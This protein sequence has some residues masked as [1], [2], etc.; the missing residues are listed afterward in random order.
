MKADLA[1]Q[2]HELMEHGMRPVTM[3]DIESR[4]PVR[5]TVLQRATSRT[6]LA[7]SRLILA[8]G[9]S[10]ASRLDRGISDRG[11]PP[12]PRRA[13]LAAVAGIAGLAIVAAVIGITS[14]GTGRP[15]FD[16][17]AVRLLAKVVG[18]AAR[19]PAPHVRD[20]QY[21]YIE[22]KAA[23]SSDAPL[24]LGVKR[25]PVPATST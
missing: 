14:L 7:S 11:N 13:I 4:A 2:I 1:G 9:G 15:A 21:M 25:P 24:P 16:R 18:A 12:R 20:S 6:R 8:P 17:G 23:V 10:P 3:T 22:T 19:Q 5:M